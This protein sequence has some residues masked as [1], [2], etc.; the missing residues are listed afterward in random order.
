MVARVSSGQCKAMSYVDDGYLRAGNVEAYSV[1]FEETKEYWQ[2]L[3]AKLN[4]DKG[5]QFATNE[6]D[7]QQLQALYPDVETPAWAKVLGGAMGFRDEITTRAGQG[8]FIA[9]RF[10]K[11][12]E[13]TQRIKHCPGPRK[14]RAALSRGIQPARAYHG[15]CIHF[16]EE[17]RHEDLRKK[18]FSRF[19]NNVEKITCN[20]ILSIFTFC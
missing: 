15:C 4:A 2:A 13:P 1:A 11:A 6:E 7:R 12:I 9:E 14:L 8:E 19:L 16:Y 20:L 17:A 5:S 18:I 3:H 10:K